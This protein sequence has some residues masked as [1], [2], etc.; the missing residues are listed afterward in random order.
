LDHSLLRREQLAGRGPRFRLLATIRDYA[1]DRLPS[2][3]R[4]ALRR[5]HA[6]YYLAAAERTRA[7]IAGSGA[8][9]ARLPAGL[10]LDHDNYRA[11]L[12]WADETGD[13]DTLLRLVTALRVF[14]MVRGH[15]AEGRDWFENALDGGVAPS[16]HRA[17][18]LS[19]GGI[20]VY[21]AG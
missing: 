13:A 5:A 6:L 19:A 3:E 8:R 18:A 9:E 20:L 16:P 11:A 10:R 7:T 12:R 17:D 14:W 21:R 15:L 4:D 2:G 1:A